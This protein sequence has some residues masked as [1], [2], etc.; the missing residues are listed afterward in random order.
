[1]KNIFFILFFSL[2]TAS[3]FSQEKFVSHIVTQGETVQSVSKNFGVS[4]SEIYK[5]NPEIKNILK[6]NT[7]L[8]LPTGSKEKVTFKKHKVKRKETLFSISKKYH[9]TIEDIKRYNKHLY[10]KRLRKREILSIPIYS[11]QT[12]PDNKDNENNTSGN[13]T[14][15]H[16]VQPKE[17]KFGIARKYG[18]TIIELEKLNPTMGENLQMGISLVVP[19]KVV[20]TD[21]SIIE[22]DDFE[23]YEVLPKEGFYRLKVKLGLTEEAIIALNPFA[24]EGLKEG[25]I[26]KIPKN[27]SVS[28]IDTNVIVNL[29]NNII[30]TKKKRLA[31]LLPFQLPKVRLDSIDSNKELLKSN[32]TLRAAIDFYTGVL[33][34]TEFA[35]DKGISTHIDVYDTEANVNKVSSIIDAKN[36]TNV[37]AVIGPLLQTNIE[38]AAL[39]LQSKKIPVFSPLS[40]REVKQYS[41]LFQSIPSSETMEKRML[42][43]IAKNSDS[44][45]IIV[46]TGSKWTKSKGTIMS[47]LPKATSI[48]PKK[49]NYFYVEDIK[50][51]LDTAKENW[52]ILDSNDPI[53]VSNVIGLLNGF[54]KVILGEYA[55]ETRKYTIRLF[56]TNKSEAFNYNDISNIHLANLNF[57]FPS[58]NKNYDYKEIAPFLV[59]YKNKY[60]VLPNRFAVRG[61][62]ITYDVLLRLA[63]T[64]TLLESVESDIQTEYIENKFHYT[65]D[66]VSGY[67]NTAFYIMKYNNE[68]KLEVVE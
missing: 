50:S 4:E 34:A 44:I 12:I 65:N 40:K 3:A 15:T 7:L 28:G 57:T 43:Y 33:M 19:S 47:A 13:K 5:L 58:V 67:I 60:G 14:T 59:S 22:D 35:K 53:L 36:F 39:K 61:F 52:V 63:S 55:N 16:I 17:T 31:I 68:L 66:P 46:I 32:A 6:A 42:S 54:P 27:N 29:E 41:N 2:L 45:N 24:K 37:D 1:M 20:V 10:S 23:F 25:M 56:A 30:N 26:L 9:I 21:S 62:D 11:K 8:I 48:V 64:D 38:K 51:K 18:I 49:G